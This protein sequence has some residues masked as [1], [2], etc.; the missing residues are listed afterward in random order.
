MSTRT[1]YPAHHS[2]TMTELPLPGDAPGEVIRMWGSRDH[3][4]VLYDD[5]GFQRLTINSTMF[6]QNTG[7][8]DDGI[9][10][11][12]LQRIKNQC[13][14]TDRWMVEIYPPEHE[15]IDAANMRHLW[16][17]APPDYGWTKEKQ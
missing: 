16:L 17:I 4:A 9:T 10:W 1:R 7:R 3:L 8:W 14:Y 2:R 11:D 15:T 13:G 12:Q 6:N 5:N